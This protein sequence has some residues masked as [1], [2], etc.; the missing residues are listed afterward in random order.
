MKRQDII[1][2]LMNEGFAQ[3]T[4]VNLNDK[5]LGM[6]AERILSEQY[7]TTTTTGTVGGASPVVNVSKNDAGTISTLKTQKRP[8]STY[9]G[10][11]K[12]EEQLGKEPKKEKSEDEKV[13]QRIHAKAESKIKKGDCIK[14]EVELLK[15]MKKNVPEKYET[16]VKSKEKKL[17]KELAEQSAKV[18]KP[19]E[20]PDQKPTTKPISNVPVVDGANKKVKTWVNKIVETKCFTSKNE[21]ME[22]IQTKLNEQEVDDPETITLPDFLTFDSIKASGGPQTQPSTKPSSPEVLP[23]TKPGTNPGTRPVPRTPFQPGPGPK[24]NPKAK[25]MEE[26]KK[27][28]KK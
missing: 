21:I 19:P 28:V 5:Q 4:L 24:H 2:K 14:S 11:M 6:L 27:P 12:E 17:E 23:T 22:L 13:L 10:E 26:T 15:R 3:K 7:G 25:A 9:E 18:K 20:E 8:F 1:S 16:Y